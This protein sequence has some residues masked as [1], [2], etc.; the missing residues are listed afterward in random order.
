[1]KCGAAAILSGAGHVTIAAFTQ[2]HFPLTFRPCIAVVAAA[3]RL[4]PF[5][6]AAGMLIVTII[7]SLMTGQGYGP[8]AAIEEAAKVKVLFL[9]FSLLSLLFTT[10]QLAALLLLR[11]RLAT[12]LEQSNPWLPQA[13][14]AAL[15][16]HCRLRLVHRPIHRSPPAPR[17]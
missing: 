2:A 8:I 15:V 6:A 16:G 17:T 4:G 7:T 13:E 3:Y 9:Q 14:A 10:L 1:M 5:G 11:Q 12:R